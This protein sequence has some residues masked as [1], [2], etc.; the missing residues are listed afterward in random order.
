MD[1]PSTAPVMMFLTVI[2]G[3]SLVAFLRATRT[4]N[5]TFDT[6]LRSLPEVH[7]ADAQ[8][9]IP[10]W[11]MRDRAPGGRP[12]VLES[13]LALLQG[14]VPRRTDAVDLG[15]EDKRAALAQRAER[16]AYF[17]A[18]PVIP[19]PVQ[20]QSQ[21]ECRA[22][23]ELGVRIRGLAA[24][25]Y[26]HDNLVS[27]TQCHAMG[28]PGLPWD[29]DGQREDPRAV[30]NTFVGESAPLKGERWTGIAPPRLPHPTFMHERCISCH[31]PN[32]RDAMKSTH[33]DR[34]SC[35]QC[36]PTDSTLEA[37]P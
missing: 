8:P 13:D 1:T 14:A 36:H 25:P 34:Q 4:D 18:P 6:P 10:Y 31:G 9:A 24:T 29:P 19:H 15:D 3:V 7:H 5:Y 12:P 27:C 16:R 26:P 22:C 28:A 35:L 21:A 33:P 2:V 30:V 23:H 32:G 11:E 37:R 20:Q 17:G